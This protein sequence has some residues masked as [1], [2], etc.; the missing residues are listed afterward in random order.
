MRSRSR[1]A[2]ARSCASPISSRSCAPRASSGA[3]PPLS[4]SRSPSA[5]DEAQA[6]AASVLPAIAAPLCTSR[7]RRSTWSRSTATGR[8]T[9]SLTA[10]HIEGSRTIFAVGDRTTR[11][12]ENVALGAGPRGE[13]WTAPRVAPARRPTAREAKGRRERDPGP[14]GAARPLVR[15][16]L[17][18]RESNAARRGAPVERGEYV[19]VLGLPGS[20]R[21]CFGHR[22]GTDLAGDVRAARA[23][24]P[25][26][27]RAR[28]RPRLR[29]DE[30]AAREPGQHGARPRHGCRDRGPCAVVAAAVWFY[31]TQRLV[32]QCATADLDLVLLAGGLGAVCAETTRHAILWAVDRHGADG[33]SSRPL[34]RLD[35]RSTR[36]TSRRSSPRPSSSRSPA[37][38]PV[39][40]RAPA[41]PVV[42]L[43]RDHDRL[44]VRARGDVGD[45]HRPR[46]SHRPDVGGS[47][48]HVGP[49]ARPRGARG[50]VVAHGA[51]LHGMGDGRGPLAVPPRG[52]R[53]MV[54]PLERPILLPALVLAGAHVEPSR[55]ARPWRVDRGGGC[56][57]ARSPSR[58][59][60]VCGRAHAVIALP[61]RGEAPPR[62]AWGSSRRARSA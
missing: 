18:G 9:G 17:P 56:L 37:P 55:D 52:A 13:V 6:R 51:L 11:F 14:R 44:R 29:A 50:V 58:S 62:S 60:R 20:G 57:T 46:A 39:H 36:T 7:A 4:P 31:T 45:A 27:D 16:E 8:A 41:D 3:G 47:P 43:G 38:M 1:G 5:P 21:T 48:R 35:S 19:A 49:G 26:V 53:A 34:P 61:Y 22:L 32:R 12:A 59:S 28:H 15:G 25:G 24:G 40:A 54:S 42:R 23:G 10:C 2:T 33:P 30:S